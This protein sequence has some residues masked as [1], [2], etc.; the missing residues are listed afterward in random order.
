MSGEFVRSA[1]TERGAASGASYVS[2]I[3]ED[4]VFHVVADC[5]NDETMAARIVQALNERHHLLRTIGKLLREVDGCRA[6]R[7]PENPEAITEARM[8]VG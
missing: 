6:G 8:L 7:P 1:S 3:G 5:R 4:G 2:T